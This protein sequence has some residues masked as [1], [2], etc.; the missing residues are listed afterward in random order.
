MKTHQSNAGQLSQSDTGHRAAARKSVDAVVLLFIGVVLVKLL[1]ELPVTRG[2]ASYL[3]LHMLLEMLS[4]VIAMLVF[5]VGWNA[6]RREP[7]GNFMLIACAFL[8]VAML[9]FTHTLSYMGMP[10]LVTPG[11]PEKAIDF[12]LAARTLAALT[13]V[14]VALLPWRP[15]AFRSARYLMLTGVFVL[16]GCLHWLLLFHDDL[17]PRTFLEGQGLTPF[18]IY[19]EYSL[20]A[21]SLV[22]AFILW[23]RMRKP[24]PFNAAGLFGAVCT[25]AMSE[26]FFTLYADV[27]DV[28]NLMGHLY[29][30]A[31]YL[32]L[33]R[34]IFVEAIERPYVQLQAS[35]NQLQATIQA[36]PDLLLEVGMDG[37]YYA[38][39]SSRSHLQ[40]KFSSAIIGK[41]MSEVL[42]PAVAQVGMN[43]IQEANRTGY[44]TGE[45]QLELPRGKRWFEFSGSRK[46]V[47]PGQEPRFVVLLRDI[48]D[49]KEMELALAESHRLLKTV[50]DAM[51]ARIFWKNNELC[52]M[53][54]NPAF[55]SDAG[56]SSPEDVIGKDDYQLGWKAQAELYR[57]DDRRVMESGVP[58][59]GYEEPQTTPDGKPIWL[60][61]SKVP[62][63][64]QSGEIIGVL[65]LYQDITEQKLEKMALRQSE[66]QLRQAQAI[67]HIGS[68]SYDLAGALSWSDE[69]YR[70]YGVS[71][72]TFTPDVESFVNL[73][74]SDDRSLMRA[75]I[76][77]CA[78]G[79]KPGELEF[80][81][82]WPDG[83]VHYIVGQGELL[84]DA[85][86]AKVQ[87]AGTAQE[88]TER[89]RVE[90]ER[91]AGEEKFRAIIESSPLALAVNDQH[92]NITFLNRKFIDTFGYTL[93]DIPTLSAWWPRA[94]PDPAYR[95]H[96]MQQWQSAEEKSERENTEFE[97]MECRVTGKDGTVRDIRFSMAMMGSLRLVIFYDMTEQK[98]SEAELRKLSQAVEQSPNSIVITDVNG[99][100]EY[101]NNNF[102]TLTGYSREEVIG[103]NPR[104]LQSGK[105][106]RATYQQMWSLLT[107]GEAWRGELVNRRKDGSEYTES[108]QISPVRQQDGRV[109]H[110]LAIKENITEAKEAALRIERLAHF[111]QLTGLPNR[112]LLN[113]HF[114]FALGRAQRN[115]EQLA[116][117]FLDLDRFKNINDTLGH[118]TGDQLLM[119]VA[120]RLKSAL[121]EED[122]LSR[123]GGD[124][125]IIVLPGTDAKGAAHVA[126]KL[127]GAVSQSW[128]FDQ[129]ELIT[130]PSIGIAIYPDDGA[131]FDT[132]SKNA[133][134]AMYRV[135]QEGRNNFCF[136]TPQMQASSVRSMQ[137]TNALRYALARN[138]LH[139][140]YQPQI[141]I[142]DGHV[143]GAEALLR[144]QHPEL[145]MISPAEFIPIAEDNGQIV[146]IGEW[147]LRTAV[148]QLR[149]WM[150]GG[151]PAMVM[152]VNL[153]AVQFHQANIASVVTN[154]LAE[155]GISPEYLELELTEAVAMKNPLTA[156][157]VMNRLHESGIR[158]SID[159]FG[160]G[161]SSLSYLKKFKVYK[162]KIDQSFVRDIT[163]D[164]DDK[165]I[166]TAI[167]NMA[168]SL[169]IQTIAEG[170][171]TSGQLAFLRL[172]GCDE[173][174]GYYFSKPLPAEKFEAFVRKS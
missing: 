133:D 3:P 157:E 171:E 32:F 12:W 42:P 71:R 35:Q 59:L 21:L 129:H 117:M 160:T 92:G 47:E 17:T 5:A 168:S 30:V 13:L 78:S 60:R 25:M 96:V 154:I 146:Q 94:Y 84:R 79:H 141:S 122:T 121:R 163:I 169:G 90:E 45:Y 167:I 120:R 27:T 68:W 149:D 145:G 4:V 100:I 150:D 138:E 69:M 51:P 54:C 142:Q 115:E 111:D 148:K 95:Q 103:N 67:A 127:I 165:A 139:L 57:A 108:V 81:C 34:A 80:R 28:Y 172:Q 147:V 26:Y 118:A 37:R 88:I 170:V 116:L 110:Y 82:I 22:T 89:K 135:K 131:D 56:V 83:S 137:L 8:G 91:R 55:A 162:L 74:H 161:Y 58:K 62:L 86:G 104:I 132:L 112:T 155:V 11:S 61:T 159:D 66:Y 72:E 23:V 153:S 164:P 107:R 128:Q 63:R 52:Y 134:A 119:E 76:D 41:T 77:A 29:K 70:I 44:A 166:V 64:N 93:V 144:W 9:D 151:L 49:R 38:F 73:I 50:I 140:H 156:I 1:P 2:I 6:Y 98:Q 14:A 87:M 130:T 124:E 36:I 65:G 48:T 158:M 7:T 16:V 46:A 53:G 143:V 39:H 99:N 85:E 33:Y 109:S 152:A 31:S 174:Q 43:A 19:Y 40:K 75:W 106:A 97:S 10:D 18:K 123:L 113:E 125:F 105:T 102:L 24:Q 173:V 15:L 20:I 101:V 126:S 136:F 114:K